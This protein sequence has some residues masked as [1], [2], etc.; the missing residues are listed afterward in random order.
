MSAFHHSLNRNRRTALLLNALVV[1]SL[2]FSSFSSVAAQDGTTPEPTAPPQEEA[3]LTPEP[4][5]EPSAEPTAE[6]SIEPTTEPVLEPTATTAEPTA[7]PTAATA[8][9]PGEGEVVVEGIM[10]ANDLVAN[11]IRIYTDADYENMNTIGATVGAED[12]ENMCSAGDTGSVWYKF[13]PSVSGIYELSTWGSTYKANISVLRYVSSTSRT[14]LVCSSMWNNDEE[15]SKLAFYA[16][17]GYTYLVRAS[18]ALGGGDLDL[19]ITRKVCPAGDLCGAAVGGDGVAIRYPRMRV[20]DSA[21]NIRASGFGKFSSFV[22]MGSDDGPLSGRF[23][24]VT[25]GGS[26]W[27]NLIVNNNVTIPGVYKPSALGYPG[28]MVSM[29]D[30]IGNGKQIYY[31]NITAANNPNLGGQLSVYADYTYIYAPA[32]TYNLAASSKDF[33]QVVYKPGVMLASNDVPGMVIMDPAAMAQAE[34]SIKPHELDYTSASVYIG[35]DFALPWSIGTTDTLIVAAPENTRVDLL[36]IYAQKD[37]AVVPGDWWVIRSN[38]DQDIYIYDGDTHAYDFGGTLTLEAESDYPIYR[39]D[40]SGGVVTAKLYDGYAHIIYELNRWYD[41]TLGGSLEGAEFPPEAETQEMVEE[42][43]RPEYSL[44]HRDV[45]VP[46]HT[47][48]PDLLTDPY[49]FPIEDGNPDGDWKVTAKINIGPFSGVSNDE[50]IFGVYERDT[51]SL[52]YDEFANAL[53]V[54]GMSTTGLVKTLYYTTAGYDPLIPALGSKGY[55]S[56]WFKYIPTVSG[57]LN[58]DT[59]GSDYDTVLNVWQGA[60]GAFTNRAYNDNYASY[61]SMAGLSV[62]AEQTYY[63]EV[64]QYDLAPRDAG[65]QSLEEGGVTIE[66]IGGGLYLNLE[67]KPCYSVSASASPAT[68]GTVIKSPAPNCLGTK[69]SKGTYVRLTA[70]PKSGY[71]FWHWEGAYTDNPYIYLINDAD[72]VQ[73]AHFTSVPGRPAL[74]SPAAGALVHRQEDLTLSWYESAPVATTYTLQLSTSPV[75]ADG[76]VDEYSPLST[77]SYT[78]TAPFFSENTTYYWRVRGVSGIGQ[79]GAWSLAR[80]L[81]VAV[82]PPQEPHVWKQ[83]FYK[84]FDPGSA[85]GDLN[86]AG[87]CFTWEEVTD[88]ASYTLQISRK[89]DWSSLVGTYTITKDKTSYLPTANLPTGIQYSWRVRANASRGPSRWTEGVPFIVPQAPPMPAPVSPA[90]NALTTDYNPLFNWTDVVPAPGQPALDYYEVEIEIPNGNNTFMFRQSSRSSI[91]DSQFE[92]DTLLPPNA[93]YYWHARA[94]NVVHNCSAWFAGRKL[95]TAVAPPVLL[96]PANIFPA[97]SNRPTFT[98]TQVIGASGYTIQISY[99]E[100]FTSLVTSG[101][102]SGVGATSFTP[103]VNLPVRTDP[104]SLLWWRVRANSPTNGPGDWSLKWQFGVPPSPP[105]PVLVS[106]AN[107]ALITTLDPTLEWNDV[108]PAAGTPGLSGYYVQFSEDKTFTGVIDQWAPVSN[109]H[110]PVLQPNRTYYWRVRTENVDTNLSGWSAVRSFRTAINVPEPYGVYD[111]F[112]DPNGG[113]DPK[114]NRPEI[115]WSAVADASSYTIQLSRYANF[116]SLLT[117]ATVSANV[118]YTNVTLPVGVPIYYRVRANPISGAFGPSGWMTPTPFTAPSALP[119]PAPLSPANSAIV[120]DSTVKLDWTDVVMPAGQTLDSYILEVDED[121]GFHSPP[122]RYFLGVGVS[123]QYV[124][125]VPTHT[126]YWRVRSRNTEDLFSGWSAVRSVRVAVTDPVLN[127]PYSEAVPSLRPAFDWVEVDG[128]SGYT[129]QIARN[130]TFT[131][132]VGT[133]TRSAVQTDYT[134][135][136]NLPAYTVLYWRVRANSPT[137]GPGNWSNAW[138][139]TPNPPSTPALLSPANGATLT[140][141]SPRFDWTTSTLPAGTEFYVYRLQLCFDA[142]CF[143]VD[144]EYTVH[145]LASSEYEMGSVPGLDAGSYYYWRVRAENRAGAYS[146]WSAVRM[147]RISP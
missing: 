120:K 41:N 147:F 2:L 94:C 1:A 102:L 104:A 118:Y 10:P 126:Y 63:I 87:P 83:C 140:D 29:V 100:A 66:Q 119:I 61:Q 76:T 24:L 125:L 52:D 38:L 18:D 121:P 34:F 54:S 59:F 134:P 15:T 51:G 109:Y 31:V 129:L 69:Y 55:A 85:D 64:T 92:F 8:E 57:Y 101:T 14:P 11:A 40:E 25:S 9:P 16:T 138:F 48:T 77:N 26:Y 123:Y 146:A 108:V 86:T 141:D 137:H 96:N 132:L 56:A 37:D 35:S 72:I 28:M 139:T 7:E 30:P 3:L 135:L 78:I 5:L 45:V 81:R 60:P 90:S 131:S 27:R 111:D 93:S 113:D 112:Y 17:G 49:H 74:K 47:F 105:I 36:K 32:G 136:V 6:P 130:A 44:F 4:T 106:P 97:R 145:S 88:A 107:T 80:S 82:P 21:G 127:G 73:V 117:S 114:T 39:L 58:I 115:R 70:T 53:D 43:V 19:M 79:T 33:T 99:N 133:Y 13:T 12:E 68:G 89:P 20:L 50:V 116:S 67:W 122:D 65:V 98:W 124:P 84:I 103:T 95:R 144:E 142:E 46:I 62:T 71:D 23:T 75:F 143:A 128:A 22:S 110:M 42:F 91:F